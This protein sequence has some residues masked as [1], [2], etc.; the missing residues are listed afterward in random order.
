MAGKLIF[1]LAG[2]GGVRAVKVSHFTWRKRQ[3]ATAATVGNP[4]TSLFFLRRF[5]GSVGGAQ[6][7]PLK[8]PRDTHSRELR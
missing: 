4:A 8:R 2:D 7:F 5:A 3:R 1:V 6:D